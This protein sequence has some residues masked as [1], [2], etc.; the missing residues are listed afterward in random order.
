MP[1]KKTYECVRRILKAVDDVLSVIQPAVGDPASRL[2]QKRRLL[3]NE[4]H[5]PRTVMLFC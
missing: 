4:L 2:F 1:P 5:K 3:V